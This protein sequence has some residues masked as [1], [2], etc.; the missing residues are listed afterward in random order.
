[1]PSPTLSDV[2][3]LT[4]AR[5]NEKVNRVSAGVYALDATSNPAFVYSY[6]GRSDSDLNSR[7]HQ[8]VGKYKY[9]RAA[10]SSSANE[11]FVAECN[12]YHDFNPTD[13]AVHPARPTNSNLKCPRCYLFD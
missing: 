9:F 3:S 8:W 12:L 6:I 13:N 10:Y 1:M 7:L 11:A 4:D 5:I 2:F